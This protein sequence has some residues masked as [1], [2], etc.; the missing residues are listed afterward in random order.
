[1][2]QSETIAELTDICVRQAQII[3]A[4]AEILSVLGAEALEDR[5]LAERLETVRQIGMIYEE[6]EI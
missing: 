4:Q 6:G 2:D 1:M 3:K 5:E